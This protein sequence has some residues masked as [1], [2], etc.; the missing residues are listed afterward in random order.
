MSEPPAKRKKTILDFFKKN[1]CDQ[2]QQKAKTDKNKMADEKTNFPIESAADGVKVPSSKALPATHQTDKNKMAEQ[3]NNTSGRNASFSVK[4]PSRTPAPQQTTSNAGSSTGS[5]KGA[6]S[7]SGPSSVAECI[8]GEN[9]N[10]S[11]TMPMECDSPQ[12]FSDSERS[13]MQNAGADSEEHEMNI[14]T[15]KPS[16]RKQDCVFRGTPIS[17]LN[18]SPGCLERLQPLV[19]TNSHTVLFKA[20][21]QYN[22]KP[23][24]P[25]PSSFKDRWDN[26]HVRMPCSNF[27]EYPVKGKDGKQT[28]RRRWDM[29]TEVL[30]CEIPGPYELEEVILTYNSRYSDRWDFK[31]LHNFF[32]T[33]IDEKE[34]QHFFSKTLKEMVRLA[35]NLP[36]LCTQPI[37]L[38]KKG[39]SRSVTF[40]QQ[41]IS[42][43]LANA[44]FCTFPRRNAR[45]KTSEYSNYPSINFNSL[46]DGEPDPKKL[47]KLRCIMNYFRRVTTTVPTGTVTFVRQ[48]VEKC[49]EWH[50]LDTSLRG[51]HVSAEGTI[52]DDG[53]GMLQVDFANKYLGGGVLGQGC[54]Q[55]E[56]RFLI[57]PEMIVSRLITE[58]LEKNEC[59]IMKGCERFSDYDGYARTFRWKENYEDK[60]PRDNWGRLCTD[61]VAI[62]ALIFHGT[63]RQFK[64]HSVVRELDKAYCGFM[65]PVVKDA[66]H[67]PAVC[68][69]NWG[70]GAFGGDRQLK[71]LIQLIAA[72]QAK[73]D[74][75]Y[76]TFD[77]KNLRDDLFR[78]HNYLTQVN[79]IGISN[80]MTLIAQYERNVVSKFF[81]QKRLSLYEYIIKVFD[82]SLENTDSEPDSPAD[83]SQSSQEGINAESVH[84]KTKDPLD[85]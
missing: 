70:C 1:R 30:L 46:F 17:K 35:L 74:V 32:T 20:P 52:E 38:L 28:V 62:D 85:F 34:R 7:F 63:A 41:Q 65:N 33:E 54:V 61:V 14:P 6:T 49:P 42:C 27:N 58:C 48:T 44:F 22:G 82:G 53:L 9:S 47:E 72:A 19:S 56:I 5:Y 18:R 10:M 69:G 78:I 36:N 64:S 13:D 57:C 16:E 15:R 21:F 23:P 8:H 84:G 2:D 60:T 66:K 59:L 80:I 11:Q 51:L 31:T 50:K 75:C 25:F 67:L 45:Q 55:E 39:R 26:D 68:T 73:R 40:S 4:L 3:K 43:L 77:D 79:P 81:R 24:D 37:P 83:F 71:A 12:L 29:I 76:F